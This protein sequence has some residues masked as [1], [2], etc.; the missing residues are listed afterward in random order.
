MFML[1]RKCVRAY[2][3]ER[4]GSNEEP[5]RILP[6]EVCIIPSLS[7]HRDA[8][9]FPEP[10]KFDPERFSEEN[11]SKIIPGTYLPFGVGPRSC[12]GKNILAFLFVDIQCRIIFS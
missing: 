12:I 2:T 1:D 5:L 9:Y 4:V 6:G 11:R 7:I 3:I 8:N 10:E